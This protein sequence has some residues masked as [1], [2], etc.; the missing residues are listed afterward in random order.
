MFL[1]NIIHKNFPY[2]L[3][4]VQPILVNAQ[5]DVIINPLSVRLSFEQV[6]KLHFSDTL[7]SVPD[8]I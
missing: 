6:I 8:G 4:H 3:V 2:D 7:V 5:L 1:D